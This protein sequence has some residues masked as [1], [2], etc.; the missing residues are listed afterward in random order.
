MESKKAINDIIIIRNNIISQISVTSLKTNQHQYQSL[1][2][3]MM[4]SQL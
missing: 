3:F 1:L 4:I 2:T